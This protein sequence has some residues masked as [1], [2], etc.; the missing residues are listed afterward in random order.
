MNDT[1]EEMEETREEARQLE[2]EQD[3]IRL[4]RRQGWSAAN[5]YAATLRDPIKKAFAFEYATYRF[6][7][8]NDKFRWN[9]KIVE[10]WNEIVVQV[11]KATRVKVYKAID[12]LEVR[13]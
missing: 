2:A 7:T 10:T 4:R 11:P 3:A 9:G 5:Q 1:I 13:P 6:G 8:D 12:A